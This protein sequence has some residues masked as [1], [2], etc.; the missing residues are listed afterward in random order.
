M[1]LGVIGLGAMG[2]GMARNLHAAQLLGAV[3]NR[4]EVRAKAL[5]AELGILA[6]ADPAALAARSDVVLTCVSRDADLLEVVSAARPGFARGAVLVDCSTVSV[7]TARQ[8]AAMLAEDGVAMLDAPVSGGREGAEQ[9]TL[10]FMVGG[11]AAVFERIRPAFEAMGRAASLMGGIGAGQATKAVNQIMAAGI[12]QAVT[13]ALAF[14]QASGLDLD[15][16]IDL[17]SG[18]AAGSW[19]LQHRGKRMVA[20][21]YQPAGFKVSLHQKDLEICKALAAELGVALPIV[22]MTLK[23]YQRLIDAGHGDDDISSLFRSKQALFRDGNLRS[24]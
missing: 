11:D 1:K 15:R 5:A 18:G 19:F 17:L 7:H 3:W 10:V 4:T 14:A 6:V 16:V 24:L 21:Q 12:N 2:A 23:H 20:G 9:G 13:E 22:E 8:V